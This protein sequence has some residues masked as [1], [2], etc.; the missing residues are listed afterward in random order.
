MR[1]LAVFSVCVYKRDINLMCAY[2]S[3]CVGEVIIRFL[4]NISL[5]RLTRS[6][7]KI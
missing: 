4:M 7:I 3:V 2:A 6:L 1:S 5:F